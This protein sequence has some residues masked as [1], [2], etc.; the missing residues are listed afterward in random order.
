MADLSRSNRERQAVCCPILFH[1]VQR[2]IVPALVIYCLLDVVCLTNG[3]LTLL[4][5]FYYASF[6][7]SS[8]Y[9]LLP[10]NGI[11]SQINMRTS[12]RIFKIIAAATDQN[13]SEKSIQKISIHYYHLISIIANFY[14]PRTLKLYTEITFMMCTKNKAGFFEIQME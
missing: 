10:Q 3:F 5:R 11:V 8:V 14:G 1:C 9:T 2:H 4:M 7:N 13:C 12:Q 6:T